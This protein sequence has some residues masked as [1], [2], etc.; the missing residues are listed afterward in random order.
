MI[1]LKFN[2]TFE[3][4]IN[5]LFVLNKQKE[6]SFA[7]RKLWTNYDKLNDKL[8]LNNLRK[9][10]NLS[11][12]EI[13]CL[14]VD[15]K[16]KFKQITTQK[17]K[18]ENDI[19]EITKEIEKLKSISRNKFETRKLFKLNKK[20]DYKNKQLSKDITFGGVNLIRR[21]SFLNNDKKANQKEIENIS[22]EYQA[23]R[24]LPINHIGETYRPNSNRFFNFDFNNNEIIYKPN[25]KIK[26]KI[27]YKISKNYQNYLLQLQNIKE[28][29][30][31]PISIKLT[32]NYIVLTFDEAKLNGYSFDKKGFFEERQKHDNKKQ[33]FIDFKNQQKETMLKD[34]LKNRYCGIDLN[35]EYIGVSILDK[36]HDNGKFKIID[37][38]CFN[39]SNLLEK[40]NNSS[41]NE[42]S[43]YINNK[44]KY[45]IGIIY[46]QLFKIIK[47]YKVSHFVIEDLNFKSKLTNKEANRKT[48]NVWNLNYQQ[49]LM[50]KHCN[51]NGIELIKIN[52][53]YSSF[54]GNISYNYFDPVN[55]AIEICRR[56][57]NK[58][59]KGNNFYPIITNTIIDTM[60]QRF[61]LDVQ[62]IKDCKNWI[63]LYKL[64]KQTKL[65][66]RWQLN[67]TKFSCFSIF[68]YKSNW[69]LY[70]FN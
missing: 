8:F 50:Q 5:K 55:A 19:I 7:F 41:S 57:L 40:S 37:K 25:R 12:Y 53:C 54:I 65:K 51:I 66:Y 68:N 33:V 14:Q 39:L 16:T 24:I 56:G 15:I 11:S 42:I 46:K 63:Q 59:K 67:D 49:N 36:Q 22:N 28:L 1:S 6:Y 48:R 70:S 38:F 69:N 31:Q 20:L 29:K 13:M 34:K 10:Y 27:N 64:F 21:L 2:I 52:P 60:I 32:S 23:K 58:F 61:G 30:I 45:E 18:L 26:I 4:E 62:V 47:H 3:S 9:Q 17:K 44:R 43:K 35:P